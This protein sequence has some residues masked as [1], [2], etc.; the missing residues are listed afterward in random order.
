MQSFLKIKLTKVS[1][2]TVYLDIWDYFGRENTSYSG[3]YRL[4]EMTGPGFIV[5]LLIYCQVQHCVG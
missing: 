5:K 4:N 2:F 1:E 3:N